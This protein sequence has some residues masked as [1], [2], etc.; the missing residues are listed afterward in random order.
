MKR[1]RLDHMYAS[2]REHRSSR[3]S[4]RAVRLST[5]LVAPHILF[6]ER[7]EPWR[8]TRSRVRLAIDRIT[9]FHA[10]SLLRFVSD[11][12]I[13]S[14][15]TL[16]PPRSRAARRLEF[17]SIFD[18]RRRA[19]RCAHA[20][21]GPHGGSSARGLLGLFALH[22]LVRAGHPEPSFQCCSRQRPRHCTESLCA[23]LAALQL[24]ADPNCQDAAK[25]RNCACV[26]YQPEQH[27]RLAHPH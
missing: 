3:R 23:W 9:I 19:M 13:S 11:K 16:R 21:G 7:R 20:N 26:D 12:M 25:H 8:V 17:P 5:P 2:S 18:V 10:S 27:W 4:T 1:S 22:F 14:F 24:T 6:H 15:S